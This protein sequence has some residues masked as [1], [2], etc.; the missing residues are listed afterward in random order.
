MKDYRVTVRFSA[1]LRRRLKEAARRTQSR[2]S[3]LIRRAV[4]RQL[5]AEEASMTAYE[6][7]VKAG[8]IGLIDSAPRDLSANPKYFDGFGQ[9]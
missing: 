2:E 8:L 6:H 1:E 7:A 9:S 5:S 3:D 4:E